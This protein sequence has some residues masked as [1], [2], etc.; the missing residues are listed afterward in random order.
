MLLTIDHSFGQSI[1]IK[2]ISNEISLLSESKFE[3][4]SQA[5]TSLQMII[6]IDGLPDSTQSDA[7]MQMSICYGMLSQFEL[8]ANEAQKAL[9]L[10]KNKTTRANILKTLGLL[11]T[12]GKNNP[13]AD[14]SF[15]LALKA[16]DEI[17]ENKDIKAL[18]LGEYANYYYE[19]YDY[20]NNL[21]L[22]KQAIAIRSKIKNDNP[23]F[24]ASLR[25]KMSATFIAMGNYDFAEKENI[26]IINL[27]QDSKSE[28]RF[29]FLGYAYQNI[30]LSN[31]HF[32]KY[33][34]SDAAFQKSIDIFNKINNQSM[35]GY[36]LTELAKNKWLQK[37]ATDGLPI[38]KKGYTLMK[39]TKSTYFLEAATVYLNILNELKSFNEGKGIINDSFVMASLADNYSTTALDYYKAKT[40]FLTYYH[41]YDEQLKNMNT[42]ITISDSVYNQQKLRQILELQAQYQIQIKEK[43]EKLLVQDNQILSQKDKLKT[44][45]LILG[46]IVTVSISLFF[47]Y[48]SAKQKLIVEIQ[49]NDLLQKEQENKLLAEKANAEARDK[50]L[51]EAIIEQ[52]KQQMLLYADTIQELENNL[53]NSTN[54]NL[55]QEKEEI[56]KH[57]QK[58]KEG[59]EYLDL[60]MAKFNTLYP[61]FSNSLIHKYPGINNSDIVFC[62]LVRINLT[63]KEISSIL[64][65]E[66]FSVYRRKYRI[67]EKMSIKTDDE[68][69]N[70]VLGMV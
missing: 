44:G 58:L 21:Q 64:N 14:S 29:P 25:Q 68:F 10:T 33:E 23:Q 31:Q 63:T 40:P 46:L 7:L 69:K 16:C 67:M 39:D 8:G 22:L 13:M 55:E 53:L 62:A 52:Q 24:Q 11:Y 35:V 9:L 28:Q 57:L 41:Q 54:K 27:L 18:V 49:S 3:N 5:L 51:K 59:K 6:K 26:A 34:A 56:Q 61:K 47:L 37:R 65:I 2:K 43:D 19:N 66:Q 45:L 70:V 4:P 50:S 1:D 36:S 12:L 30:G 17:P 15:Q 60:F 32:K 20:V 48:R 42:I 38:I